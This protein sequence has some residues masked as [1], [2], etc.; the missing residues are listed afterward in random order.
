MKRHKILVVDDD[1]DMIGQYSFLFGDRYDLI[2]TSS[3]QEVYGHPDLKNYRR[4]DKGLSPTDF[5]AVAILDQ[6]LAGKTVP[7]NADG[8]RLIGY[9]KH[10]LCPF[11]RAII[12]TAHRGT[13]QDRGF[14]AGVNNADAYIG[15]AQ[16]E[17]EWWSLLER[18]VAEYEIL[19][20]H[21]VEDK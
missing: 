8:L 11:T 16:T 5:P 3:L 10:E 4:S 15:K 6:N 13:P 12:A 20:T 18:F 7:D 14:D 2:L 1:P 9:V 19:F 17:H 21:N